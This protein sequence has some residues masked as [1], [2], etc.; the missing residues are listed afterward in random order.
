MMI[1]RAAA[2]TTAA[3]RVATQRM[4]RMA[5]ALLAIFTAV[6]GLNLAFASPAAAAAGVWV[7]YGN[8]NP[9]AGSASHWKCGSTEQVLSNIYAQACVIRSPNYSAVQT[10]VIVRNNRSS[11]ASVR[12]ETDFFWQ[13][14]DDILNPSNYWICGY[15]GVA[16]NSWS[17]C[18][19]K[20]VS[21]DTLI[22]SVGYVND[23][24]LP[25][26]TLF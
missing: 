26:T 16:G 15:S 18:F 20:T 3:A 2:S 19:G 13:G 25:G 1:P 4:K 9:V 12:A 22:S 23:N 7:P 8:D 10:A 24:I 17:V 6:V 11:L 5:S 14:E 21:T